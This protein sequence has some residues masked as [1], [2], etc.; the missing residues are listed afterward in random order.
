VR[1]LLTI[2]FDDELPDGDIQSAELVASLACVTIAGHQFTLGE[3]S[4]TDRIP[5]F[6]RWQGGVDWLEWHHQPEAEDDSILW[7]LKPVL[8]GIPDKS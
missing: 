1:Y 5:P 8:D 7:S 6:H 4:L 2:E 3:V